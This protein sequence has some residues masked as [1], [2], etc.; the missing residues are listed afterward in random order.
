MSLTLEAV[1]EALKNVM[2]PEINKPLLEL[3]M[4]DDI[5]IT[6]QDVALTVYLTTPACPLKEKIRTDVETALA[7]LPDLGKVDLKIDARTLGSKQPQDIAPLVK[8]FVAIAS[9]KGGVGKST[10]ALNVAL[11]LVKSGAKVGLM[12]ADIFGPS[13]PHMLGVSEY[14]PGIVDS[15]IQPLEIHGLKVMSIGFFVPADQAVVWRGPMLHKA[16]RQCLADVQWGELDYLLMD[17]PPGTGDVQLSI[18]QLVPLTGAL[19]V[20]TPQ[21]VALLDVR[22]CLAM[23]E[24]T[25]T[26]IFGMVENMSYFRC[27]D[28]GKESNIFGHGGAVEQ[29]ETMDLPL[30]GQIP[31]RLSIREGGDNGRPPVL[32]DEEARKDYTDIAEKLAAQISLFHVNGGQA[33]VLRAQ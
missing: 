33:Q 19:V 14:Q 7:T 30:L 28:C 5:V 18:A 26:K 21:D 11:A 6:G 25:K 23:F 22:K 29:A 12:D 2:D 10:T 24:T 8:N 20:S 13:I 9:G 4:I 16:I 15:K 31:I 3:N 32:D 27:P 1:R 17:F